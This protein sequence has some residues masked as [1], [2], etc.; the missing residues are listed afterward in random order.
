MASEQNTIYKYSGDYY[1]ITN[2]Y[3]RNALFPDDDVEWT[4]TL[5]RVKEIDRV[6]SRNK[7][8]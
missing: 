3:L 8:D 1:G 5:Q 2:I 4:K 7:L 6:L